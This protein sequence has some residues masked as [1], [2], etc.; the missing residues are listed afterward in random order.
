M[1][2]FNVKAWV[3]EKTKP[4][5]SNMIVALRDDTCTSYEDAMERWPVSAF[6]HY[7]DVKNQQQ[8]TK[9]NARR[10]EEVI[11]PQPFRLLTKN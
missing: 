6:R 8:E 10:V 7:R 9:Q 1:E 5:F 11:G 4:Q 3:A 2:N